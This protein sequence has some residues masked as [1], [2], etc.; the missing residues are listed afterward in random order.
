MRSPSRTAADPR[1]RGAIG[2]GLENNGMRMTL[3]KMRLVRNKNLTANGGLANCFAMPLSENQAKAEI[4]AID[5]TVEGTNLD[6]QASGEAPAS[7]DSTPTTAQPDSIRSKVADENDYQ[8]EFAAALSATSEPPKA[9]AEPA[10]ETP[11]DTEPA[12][13]ATDSTEP[14]SQDPDDDEQ[15]IKGAPD[16]IRVKHLDDSDKRLMNNAS[17]MVRD[18]FAKNIPDA[19]SKLTSNAESPAQE[20]QPKTV[21]VEDLIA[22]RDNKTAEADNLADSLDVKAA[23]VAQR[24][25][26][27]IERRIE[28]LKSR[29]EQAQS[30]KV[31]SE[32]DA[33]TQRTQAIYPQY[34]DQSHAIHKEAAKIWED[35]KATDNP[36]IYDPNNTFSVYQMAANNLGIAPNFKPQPS[37][38]ST[39]A[40]SSSSATPKPQAIKQ[41]AVRSTNPA[42]PVASGGERSTQTGPDS[43]VDFGKNIRTA[44]D[45]DREVRNLLRTA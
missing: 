17:R 40:K 25:A 16:R 35:L 3:S 19:I 24:E 13:E 39:V 31:A 11:A 6:A 8:K 7:N 34:S 30:S 20:G 1:G 26:F 33:A 27:A 38:Q 12:T 28:Q 9:D 42:I 45:Y 37:A 22:E 21:T 14:E 43:S 32:I 36:L 23:L 10:G 44:H 18:G 2:T 5:S 15:K 41:S 4:P 29:D